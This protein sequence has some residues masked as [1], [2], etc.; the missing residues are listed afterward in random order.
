MNPDETTN[1]AVPTEGAPVA[2]EAPA[3]A[4]EAPVAPAD[5]EATA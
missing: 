2:P 4:P 5:G 1:P 3:A